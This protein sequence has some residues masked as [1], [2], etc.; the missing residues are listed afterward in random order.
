MNILFYTYFEIVPYKGGTERST[1]TTAL[2]LRDVYGHR[3][4][5]AFKQNA[6]ADN[7]ISEFERSFK[8]GQDAC[9]D[10]AKIIC[11]NEIDVVVN[12]GD[13]YMV[14]TIADAAK[15]SGRKCKTVFVHHYTPGDELRAFN[16]DRLRQQ[17]APNMEGAKNLLRFLFCP[18]LFP[19]QKRNLRTNYRHCC[20]RFDHVVLL[21]PSFKHE[22]LDFAECSDHG[23]FVFIPN[24]LSLPGK[25][26]M[27]DYEKKEKL[28]LLVSRLDETQKKIMTALQIWKD[29]EQQSEFGDWKLEIVG[30]GNDYGLYERYIASNNLK[31]A[32]LMGRQ[33]PES[34]YRR[35]SIFLM[36]SA[37]EGWGLTIT[38]AQQFGCVPVAFETYSS[39]RDIVDDEINGYV[40]AAG[41]VKG[42]AE[43]LKQLMR[44]GELC[45]SIAARAIEKSQQFAPE[46]LVGRWH[47]LFT[48]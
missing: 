43:R 24:A 20:E 16:R 30:D 10:L 14:D 8:L 1:T 13:F 38:E 47:E 7:Q 9:G 45:R 26:D 2:G 22:F 27:A 4:F 21:S 33:Y 31:R 32:N 29:L 37:C 28:L 25:L 18:L 46:N 42:Y 19:R 3:I 15:C 48:S 40:V 41:D 34:Y 35:A 5:S 36:T 17:I 11:E 12:E 23:N 39:L 6:S 44:N